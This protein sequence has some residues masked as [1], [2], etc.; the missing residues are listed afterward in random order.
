[1]LRKPSGEINLGRGRHAEDFIYF[2]TEHN[3][4]I[5]ELIRQLYTKYR[6]GSDFTCGN[7][8]RTHGIL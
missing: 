7:D 2:L 5:T 3:I 4:S 8:A 1:L 6:N